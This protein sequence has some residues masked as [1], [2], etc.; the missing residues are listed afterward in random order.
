MI[1]RSQNCERRGCVE[2]P[3]SVDRTGLTRRQDRGL[4]F[5]ES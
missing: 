4:T 5:T 1:D 2:L 3:Q